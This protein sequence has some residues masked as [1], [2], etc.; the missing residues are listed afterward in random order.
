MFCGVS[1]TR[2]VQYAYLVT[3]M[4]KGKILGTAEGR[5]AGARVLLA[6]SGGVDSAVSAV[7]LQEMGFRVVGI[8]MKNFCYAEAG[9]TARSCCSLEAV[10]DARGVCDRLDI[11]HVIADTEEI[12]GTAVYQNFL[13][14]YE[15][16]RTPNPCVRCNDVVRFNTLREYADRL[17]A[18][19]VA[20]GH[21][22]RLFRTETGRVYVARPVHKNKDQSYFLSGLRGAC[23]ER[24]LFPLG[25]FDK[26]RVREKAGAAGLG[27]TEKPESQE[28]CFIPE[29]SLRDFLQGKIPLEPGPI[30][31]T[32]GNVLGRHRGLWAYTVGQRRR[33]GVAVG[34]PMYVVRL[35]GERN[36]LVVGKEPALY[37]NTLTCR[38]GWLDE[39]CLETPA[40]VTAQIRSRSSARAV[41]RITVRDGTARVEFAEPQR[42]IAPGQ[43]I[44][45]Y[46]GDVVVGAGVIEKAGAS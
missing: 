24:V 46:S 18:D 10:D 27:V 4:L 40:D 5:K 29:G 6:M 8:T 41:S 33:L 3:I 32:E 16:G 43:T 15:A 35:D 2:R 11:S 45:F 1:I 38:L 36:V 17:D 42:A 34:E 14:E 31:D 12:F 21:Y 13:L 22:A 26:A 39:V 20:T 44:A 19:Y 23:L 37:Q 9:A 30:E 25:D 28:V 7:V